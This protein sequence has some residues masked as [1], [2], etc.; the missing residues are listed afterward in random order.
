MKLIKHILF[1]FL[2]ISTI[3][4]T[5]SCDSPSSTNWLFVNQ[6]E[7]N[8]LI[9]SP[10]EVEFEG[11]KFKLNI[12]FKE[13]EPSRCIICPSPIPSSQK[14]SFTFNLFDIKS[15][16]AIKRNSKNLLAISIWLIDAEAKY[17]FQTNDFLPEKVIDDL[18]MGSY[19]II[20]P[21]DYLYKTSLVGVV[22]FQ[23]ESKEFYIK[24]KI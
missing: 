21:K 12:S 23:S 22:K 20:L 14:R 18:Y 4:L 2:V 15:N 5:M 8:K 9:N 10:E 19:S 16:D 3:T 6:D 24:N 17:Y 11:R 13:A 7:I 1:S